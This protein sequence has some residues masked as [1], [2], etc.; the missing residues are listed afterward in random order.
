MLFSQQ[1]VVGSHP[2]RPE[3]LEDQGAQETV[4]SPIVDLT[5]STVFGVSFH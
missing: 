5:M 2:E 3:I 4:I 1:L